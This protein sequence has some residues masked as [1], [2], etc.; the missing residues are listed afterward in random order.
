MMR[1]GDLDSTGT[2]KLFSMLGIMFGQI[3]TMGVG[4]SALVLSRL[5]YGHGGYQFMK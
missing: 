5:I 2:F 4:V 3:F 1:L